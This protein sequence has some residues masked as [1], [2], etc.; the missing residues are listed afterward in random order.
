MSHHEHACC[1]IEYCC[2]TPAKRIEAIAA[3]LKEEATGPDKYDE[4]AAALVRQKVVRMASIFVA[5][6]FFT[7]AEVAGFLE[8][9]GRGKDKYVAMATALLDQGYVVSASEFIW[10]RVLV[11]IREGLRC[12]G[13][14]YDGE[15]SE[16]PVVEPK[17]VKAE[18]IKALVVPPKPKPRPRATSTKVIR[19]KKK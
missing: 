13:I 5:P 3:I 7:E 4:M 12:I 15:E 10:E 8:A 17:T 18:P 14:P 6:A 2:G 9:F 1:A 16:E 19:P 11:E